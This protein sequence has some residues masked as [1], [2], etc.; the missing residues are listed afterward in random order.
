MQLRGIDLTS[1]INRLKSGYAAVCLNVRGYL[2]GGYAPRNRLT[3]AII[4]IS[5]AIQT[6][7][8]L[9]D[10]TG[11]GPGAGYTLIIAS[12]DG[13][14]YASSAGSPSP[15]ASGLSG[16]PISIVPFR[17]NASVQPW[18]YV[19][20]SAASPDVLILNP[21]NSFHCAGML[22]VRSDGLTRKMGIAEPQLAA[23]V[24]FPGG[25]GGPSQIFYYYV[26][27]ASETGAQSNPSPVS[28]PGTNSQSNP[29]VTIPASSHATN[30]TFNA[31]QYEYVSPQIR[32]TG[33]VAAGTVTDFV[34]VKTGSTPFAIPDGTQVASVT[35]SGGSG[36]T[37][38]T[39]AIT[40]TGGGGT[41][42][43][44]TLVVTSPT[45]ST[46]TLT[47]PGSG[48]TSVPTASATTGGTPPLLEVVL[49]TA[50]SVSGVTIDLNWVGQNSGT[51]VLS[52]VALFLLGSQIGT[53]K[54]PGIQNQS[55][56]TDTLQ[57]AAGDTWG[58][59]GLSAAQVNDP[60]F[61][62][63]VQI[64]T[65]LS[66]GSDRSFINSMGMTVYY[67]TQNA[68]ITPVPSTDPQVDK[69]DFY[70]QGGGLA[71]PT[72]VG[73][74]PNSATAFND[75]LSDLAAASNQELEFD[76]FEPFPSIDLP[77]S[78]TL[79]AAGQILTPTTG[80]IFNIRW[81]PGTVILIGS[82]DQLG[83]TAVRRPTSTTSWDFTNNDST[84][85]AIPDGTSLTWNIAEPA[86]AQQP[87]PY[88]WGPT[89]NIN[90]V[91]A[92]G[93]PLRPGTLYW[94]KGNN[95]DSAPDTNQ[96]EVTDPSE[97]LVNGAMSNGLGV[98][99]SIK[100]AWIIEPNFYNALATVTGTTGSTWS[101]QATAINR[102]LFI[103]RC[104]AVEGGGRIF[105]RVD[106]G[107]LVSTA[108]S[109]PTSI[110]D[111][112]L[113]PLFSHEGSVPVSITR[114]GITFWPPDDSQPQLQQFNV[115]LGFLYYSYADTNGN[116]HVLTFDILSLAWVLDA[117]S[118][119]PT[120]FASNEGQSVQGV[121]VGCADNTLRQ[122]SNTGTET[123]TS[124]VVTPAIGGSGFQ[125]IRE[126]SLEYKS[127]AAVNLTFIAVDTT[128]GS[129]APKPITLP[130]TSGAATKTRF[131]VSI[132]KWQ[133]LQLR[134]DSTDPTL[135]VYLEG[136]CLIGRGWGNQG[137][138]RQIF[139]FAD[140]GGHGP[141]P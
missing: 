130:S 65:Q 3:N 40:F 68:A 78:G 141:M 10:S 31:A 95:L 22:K 4:T 23:T 129:F 2:L 57:G 21:A 67:S 9:N 116:R 5:A 28:I 47:S 85:P 63:G 48:Y 54:F 14:L 76:N 42:A 45:A 109:S 1:P 60:S 52:S 98:L 6:I 118:T 35:A 128:N 49:T 69:V 83:Y 124:T 71:N 134:F 111:S 140:S 101:L 59:T 105:F 87:L 26:Y 122:L 100:R 24:T 75:T 93:D 117:Y 82:P 30:F 120:T 106:D 113:Y 135:N 56:S 90:F 136:L 108:G 104:I 70:R 46:A 112:S 37:P 92:V 17:P 81:L 77:R 12:A 139:P 99:F 97:P 121:L 79:T 94:C 8:R 137:P 102:G 66:G 91:Y 39:Y 103:P 20:D 25:G 41:G 132:N 125:H 16:N 88:M 84:V 33:S 29:S 53:A 73:T 18:A 115:N 55:F 138:Y 58:I 51:G 110:T 72:Y 74:G 126:F 7:Q 11:A 96:L 50:V 13:N 32:T 38:G 107:V 61:G 86:L 19:S 80:D 123:V 15:V 131:Q 36:M 34:I 119:T 27:R 133:W 62:F 114:N 64:T 89:D 44:G 127:N 43:A